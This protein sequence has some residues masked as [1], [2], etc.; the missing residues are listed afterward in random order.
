MLLYFR[1]IL[2]VHPQFYKVFYRSAAITF[3]QVLLIWL[4]WFGINSF[5]FFGIWGEI[6]PYKKLC[7]IENKDGTSVENFLY[8]V[9]IGMPCIIICVLYVRIYYKVRRQIDKLSPQIARGSF[10]QAKERRLTVMTLIIFISFVVCCLPA[11]VFQF[12][13]HDSPNEWSYTMALI[14]CGLL[15]IINPFIYAAS[16]RKYRAAYAK[17]FSDLKIWDRSSTTI[18]TAT[19]TSEQN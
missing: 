10:S 15:T 8:L 6:R 18:K 11:V 1:Y 2:I 14:F 9:G 12:G 7:K 13:F 3:Y 19:T 17:L 5:S 16:N 4:V